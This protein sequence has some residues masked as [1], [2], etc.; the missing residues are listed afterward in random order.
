MSGLSSIHLFDRYGFTLDGNPIKKVMSDTL[1]VEVNEPEYKIDFSRNKGQ[2]GTISWSDK[3]TIERIADTMNFLKYLEEQENNIVSKISKEV[4]EYL[5]KKVSEFCKI[6]NVSLI[7]WSK[8]GQLKQWKNKTEYY[9]NDYL[10]CGVE[11]IQDEL[12]PDD[13]KLEHTLLLKYY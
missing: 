1:K 2:C 5:E 10:V 9:Y 6:N 8:N 13:M 3:D 12:I 7:D 11:I 4:G